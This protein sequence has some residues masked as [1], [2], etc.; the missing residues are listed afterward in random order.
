MIGS[1]FQDF[2]VGVGALGIAF[3]VADTIRH[4]FPNYIRLMT[5]GLIMFTVDAL[6]PQFSMLHLP[7][8]IVG[9]SV[10]KRAVIRQDGTRDNG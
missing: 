5:A 2:L 4:Y 3:G 8:V 7:G 6:I 9:S 10:A 1:F